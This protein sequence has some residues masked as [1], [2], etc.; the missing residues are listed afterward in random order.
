MDKAKIPA[1]MIGG[2]GGLERDE[3]FPTTAENAKNTQMV[4]SEW[5]LGPL[6]PSIDPK[7]NEEFWAKLGKAWQTSTKEARRR[8]CAN[9]EYFKNDTM[10]QA[11]MERV[12]LNK[13]DAGAGGRGFCDK[14]EFI[15]HNLRVCQAWEE[16]EED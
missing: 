2:F 16:R 7:A 15:C 14:F 4:I 10:T 5:S 12:P 6:V 8:F 1:L 11:K 13:Y 9:C 3:P